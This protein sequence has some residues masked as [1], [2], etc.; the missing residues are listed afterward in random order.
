MGERTDS[1]I[2]G[3]E[4]LAIQLGERTYS[5]TPQ[6][7][8]RTRKFRARYQEL[9]E[10][11]RETDL[12]TLVDLIYEYDQQLADDKEYIETYEG[13]LIDTKGEKVRYLRFYSNGNTSTD[14]NHY[15]EVEVYATPAK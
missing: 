3:A 5:I 1:Q 9:T 15:I 11:D 6:P 10:G 8:A 2:L 14:M 7:R 12:D 4:P 13:R